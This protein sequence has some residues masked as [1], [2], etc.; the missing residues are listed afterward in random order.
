MVNMGNDGYL[1]SLDLSKARIFFIGGGEVATSKL[2]R[3]PDRI[4][5]IVIVA[6]DI[7]ASSFLNKLFHLK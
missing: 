6:P 7:S 3:L 4:G 2:M 5:E 1:V